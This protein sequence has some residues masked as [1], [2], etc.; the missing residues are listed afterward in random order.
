VFI[1]RRAGLASCRRRPVNSTL[2]VAI[3]MHLSAKFLD[4]YCE[5]EGG[6]LVDADAIFRA[7]E[8][9]RH[10][11]DR[12]AGDPTDQDRIDVISALRR[13]VNSRLKWLRRTY[14][15]DCL[16]SALGK[17]QT[18][19]RLQEFGIVRS[20]IIKDLLDIRN[21]I[22]HEDSAPPD[23]SR[24]R[25]HVDVV[26]YFLKSTDRLLDDRNDSVRFHHEDRRQDVGVLVDYD[27][28]WRIEVDASVLP[29]HIVHPEAPDS[30]ALTDFKQR[31]I[32]GG[33][34][35]V[36]VSGSAKLGGEPLLSLARGCFAA[37][38]YWC[39]D[40]DA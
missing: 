21:L 4:W 23:T 29:V 18:L 38:G 6:H 22:E 40:G 24:C 28:G 9:W 31:A 1:M 17:K 10:A 34:G 25:H 13:A 37:A 11:R 14:N 5:S 8:V 35:L 19:E 36:R 27:A 39:D 30:I 15:L 33:N 3:R 32:R 26:W 12:V 16:P 20:A 7:Y 2:G